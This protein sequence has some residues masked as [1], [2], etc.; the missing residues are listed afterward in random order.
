MDVITSLDEFDQEQPTEEEEVVS[1]RN[2]TV[3]VTEEMVIESAARLKEATEYTAK[4]MRLYE[5]A[6]NRLEQIEKG[7]LSAYEASPEEVELERWCEMRKRM[8]ASKQ[9]DQS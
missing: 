2:S 8:K 9:T 6:A 1:E 3:F 7:V 5:L 4:I